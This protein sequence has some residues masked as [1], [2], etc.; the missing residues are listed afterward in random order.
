MQ[1]DQPS[2]TAWL[3]ALARARH[4]L[5]DG[6]QVFS[7]PMALPILGPAQAA[8]LQARPRAGQ[9]PVSRLMRGPLAA[10]SR[11][12][13]DTLAEA[14]AAGATQ[15]VLLGAG[16]D[17]LALRHPWPGRLQ[18]FELDH[19]ATQAWKRQLLAQAGLAPQAGTHWVP[20]DF[21]QQDF[22]AAL[23]AAGWEAERPSMVV[24][25]GVTVYLPPAQVWASLRR[26]GEV[27]APGSALVF[28]FMRRPAP[29]NLPRRLVLAWLSRRYGRLGEP[30]RCLL[31]ARGLPAE[32][33]ALGFR[34]VQLFDPALLARHYRQP[35]PA[36]HPAG[37]ATP[38]RPARR[39]AGPGH[40]FGG[41]V[42][43]W[44]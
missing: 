34:R 3:C 13:D 37:V 30:W 33:A 26:L 29:L 28:D 27:L 9:N 7:D 11:L 31:E 24:W 17:T 15:C 19:P 36:R 40:G 12:A 22:I 4:Q 42:C 32:L 5:L 16:L 21:E 25:L 14:V 8:A 39:G 2:R 44:R 18:V 38:S 10:R 43:A 35:N 41:L 6:G 20:V 23:Q 1:A